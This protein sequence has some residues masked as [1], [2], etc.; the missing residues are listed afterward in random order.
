LNPSEV[1]TLDFSKCVGSSQR[2]GGSFQDLKRSV[3][4]HLFP[5][6]CSAGA[7]LIIQGITKKDALGSIRGKHNL[8]YL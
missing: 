3:A 2:P 5:I 1:R 7:C 4:L 6:L 8:N